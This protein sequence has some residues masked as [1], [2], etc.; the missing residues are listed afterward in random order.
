MRGTADDVDI[1]L[2]G[3]RQVL[4]NK[5]FAEFNLHPKRNAVKSA[6]AGRDVFDD[7]EYIRI[8]VPGERDGIHRPAM[9]RDRENFPRQY[10]AFKANTS[11]D[12]ASGTPLSHVLW[13]RPAQVAELAYYNCRTLEQLAAMPDGS[14]QKFPGILSLRQ[15]ARDAIEVAKGEAPVA[16]LREEL[17]EE[18]RKREELE[19]RLLE[20]AEELKALQG[21]R[22]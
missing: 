5:V 12:A 8:V 7:V 19:F 20:M 13:L 15:K 18:R 22:K 6:E 1:A 11:Q 17:T 4:E 21:K 16:K 14:A 3:N 10:A 2:V 9:Q